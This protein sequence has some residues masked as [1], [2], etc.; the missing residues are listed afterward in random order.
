MLPGWGTSGLGTAL[1][2]LRNLEPHGVL[3]VLDPS[4]RRWPRRAVTGSG[5][6]VLSIWGRTSAGRPLIVAVRH[7]GGFDWLIVGAREMQA[8]EQTEFEEWEARDE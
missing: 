7:L 2:G 1:D 3:Q 4:R 6:Q 8:K 5:V